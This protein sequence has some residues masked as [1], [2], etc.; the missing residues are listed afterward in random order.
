MEIFKDDKIF[1][2][3]DKHVLLVKENNAE[4][5]IKLV[6]VGEWSENEY[7]NF[8]NVM[9]SEDYVE[10]IEK[11]NLQVFC[12]DNLLELVGDTNII[13]YSQNPTYI[14]TD[15]MMHKYKILAK[16][17]CSEL[18]NSKLLF[19]TTTKYPL[20]N[21]NIPEN[22][23][24]LRKFFKINKRFTYTDTKTNIKF[25][26]NVCKCSKYESYDATDSDLHNNLNSANIIR[27]SHRYDFYIDITN[28]SQDIILQSIIK[29]EQAL[30]LF[31]LVISKKQ[32]NDIIKKY[33]DLV[34]K[35]IYKYNRYNKNPPLLTPKP[36]TLE[37]K[38]IVEP[39]D[40][41]NI[42]ILTE[43][44]VTEKADGERLLMFIDNVGKVYLINNT[45]MVIDTG[46]EASKELYNSLIDGEYISC[47]NR[48]DNPSVGLFAAFD[49]YYYGGE[50]ITNL[51]LIDNDVKENSRYKYLKNTEKYIKQKSNISIDYFVKEHRYTDNILKDCDDI[52][53][54]D[55]KF[56]YHIDGLIFTPAK[57]GLYAHYGN[58]PVQMT[59]NVKWDKVFKW[60][61]PEQNTID[62]L[63]KFGNIIS[64]DGIRYREI[65]LYVGYNTKQSDN[66]SI[67]NALKELYNTE[68]RKMIREKN[69]EKYIFKLFKPNIHYSEGVEKS[70]VRLNSK[71][72]ARCESGELIDGDKIV[73][74]RYILDDAIIPSMR[75]IPM[76]IREDKTRIYNTGEK[77]KT[78]NDNTVA[79]NIWGTIH[80]PV[81]ESI[82]RGKAP[83]LKMDLENDLLQSNDIYYSRNI[84]REELLSYNMQQFHN[85]GIKNMLYS[86]HKYKDAL[87][88]LACGEGG[89]MNRWIE[90]SYKFVLG[91]DY[92]KNNIYNP[93]SGAYSR[94][95]SARDRFFRD[96][97]NIAYK[98][99]F[100]NIVY[101]AGD[102][103]KSI[104]DGECSK[105]IDD[106]ESFNILKIVLNKKNT[107]VQDHYKKI[108]SKGSYGFD[109][110][111]CM[112][113]IHYFFESEEKIN[114]F[115]KNVNLMLKKGGI[116]MCTFM[117]GKS[118]VEAIHN[119]GGDIIEGRKVL[120]N[121]KG[122]GIPLWSIIR[123]YDVDEDIEYNKKVDVLI[124][125]TKKFI[126]EF[127]VNFDVLVKKCKEYNLELQESEL[128]SQHFNRIKSEI[129]ADDNEKTNLHKII[130]KL[131]EDDEL[132]TFSFFNR[133]C[134][135]KK[136]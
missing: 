50:K 75:W 63:A 51:Q 7:T 94:L 92:V 27:S 32:Q 80:N 133:W 121:S 59:D 123:R 70:Y 126:P 96:R 109:V 93:R 28:A 78:A 21:E 56:P 101:A 64:I 99:I 77:S 115:L 125:A 13:K 134:I 132:K 15:N 66:Y 129:P 40:Y 31:P 89:D 44:T 58:K 136:L 38:Y 2:Y 102:C 45:Y 12:E 74:F 68:Y 6:G 46:L 135:F 35:D 105:S 71:L 83:I 106:Q 119:N 110:C 91:I 65:S 128:F 108:A 14:K 61:P 48:L 90:N 55:N 116:F 54:G 79:V 22:W 111:S 122:K 82:I 98:K 72:E 43:Y 42:S 85:I 41:T 69:K 3:I 33:S 124:E 17:E 10:T 117:D 131:D 1:S 16:D 118:V 18:F 95:I 88:E 4:C 86:K 120:G 103:G 37:K 20:S 52:L 26:V 57:L 30:Y 73:E 127:I 81:T 11:H 62:F 39:D 104:M 53:S 29:M 76:R 47:V 24:D 49:M 23:K 9:K 34:S 25:I 87:L 67:N 36:V 107:N 60:K 130:M 8:I 113:A 114:A 97:D 112:F 5:I 19:L 100:P 84:P